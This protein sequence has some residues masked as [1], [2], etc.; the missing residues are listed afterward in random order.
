MFNQLGDDDHGDDDHGHGND[1]DDEDNWNDDFK[2]SYLGPVSN[3][4]TLKYR[5]LNAVTIVTYVLTRI[6]YLF[7]AQF[8]FTLQQGC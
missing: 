4:D 1:D 8:Y 7:H 3:K 2:I 5:F 6:H